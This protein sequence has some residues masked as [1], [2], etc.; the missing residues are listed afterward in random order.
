MIAVRVADKDKERLIRRPVM[1]QRQIAAVIIEQQQTVL[2]LHKKAA[3]SEI[4]DLYRLHPSGSSPF[5]SRPIA[6]A[7]RTAILISCG[8]IFGFSWCI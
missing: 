4:I 3:V 2:R 8:V 5:L 7:A 6:S 1:D